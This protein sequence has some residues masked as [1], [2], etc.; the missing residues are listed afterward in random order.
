MIHYVSA[1]RQV[2]EADLRR[3]NELEQRL[4]DANGPEV[5]GVVRSIGEVCDSLSAGLVRLAKNTDS[6]R[7]VERADGA[8]SVDDQ[9]IELAMRLGAAIRYGL[10]EKG[11]LRQA[12]YVAFLQDVHRPEYPSD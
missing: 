1:L 2:I 3:L 7:E 4:K 10:T 12:D 5:E 11:C 9:Q 8:P 6:V